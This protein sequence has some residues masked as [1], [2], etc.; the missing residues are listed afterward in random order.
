MYRADALNLIKGKDSYNYPI[1]EIKLLQI[2][3]SISAMN[4]PILGLIALGKSCG[5]H[6]MNLGTA[7]F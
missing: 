3:K 5:Q 6:S 4:F 1:F 2:V 7:T